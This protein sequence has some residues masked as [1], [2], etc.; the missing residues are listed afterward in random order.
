VIASVLQQW[1]LWSLSAAAAFMSV[2]LMVLPC[3]VTSSTQLVLP[4]AADLPNADASMM[5][6]LHVLQMVM[7]SLCIHHAAAVQRSCSG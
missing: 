4:F 7:V 1:S 3:K 5:R 6:H 2:L